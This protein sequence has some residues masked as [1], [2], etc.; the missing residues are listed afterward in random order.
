[1]APFTLTDCDTW[2][3]VNGKESRKLNSSAALA[4]L[5][6]HIQ[7]IR[8]IREVIIIPDIRA[9]PLL[10]NIPIHHTETQEYTLTTTTIVQPIELLN[11]Y[12]H[13]TCQVIITMRLGIT[14]P[15]T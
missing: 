6:D 5:A 10:T 1:M 12:T 14:V 8:D 13:T 15:C 9:D 11:H 7:D 2:Q 4:A 3:R